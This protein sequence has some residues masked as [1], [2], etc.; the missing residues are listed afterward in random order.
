MQWVGE[1][2]I[3]M[4][5]LYNDVSRTNNLKSLENHIIGAISYL[6]IDY[7]YTFYS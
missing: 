2:Q 4:R 6:I 3:I 1:L 7:L 5:K